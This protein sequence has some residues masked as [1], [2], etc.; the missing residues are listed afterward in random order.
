[1][2]QLQCIILFCLLGKMGLCQTTQPKNL[3]QNQ[4]PKKPTIHYE[5][6]TA[7]IGIII[8]SSLL[9]SIGNN[10]YRM[11]NGLSE[12]ELAFLDRRKINAMDRFA[13]YQHVSFA[14]TISDV[15]VISSLATSGLLLLD[16]KIR[17]EWFVIGFMYAEGLVSS[18]GIFQSVKAYTKRPRPYVFQTQVPTEEK[19]HKDALASFFSG[20]TT[21]AATGTFL[22]YQIYKEFFPNG[23]GKYYVLGAAIAL[24]A[25]TGT[26][27]ILAGKHYLSDVLVGY[28]VGAGIGYVLPIIHKKGKGSSPFSLSVLPNGQFSLTFQF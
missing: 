12:T 15:G 8:G 21:L 13:T 18:I 25:I 20:H 28:A 5:F 10:A 16:K 26:M 3:P 2:K 23:S 14:S 11:K 1:M 7:D 27:R 4:K 17:K 9:F 19:L 24:P 6:K 22:T